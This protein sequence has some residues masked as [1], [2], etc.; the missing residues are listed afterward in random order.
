[1]QCS[2]EVTRLVENNVNL[3]HSIISKHFRGNLSEKNS[4]FDYDDL[5][6][7][8][9]I[10]LTKAA[11]AY[12]RE[13]GEFSTIAYTAIRNELLLFVKREEKHI[14]DVKDEELLEMLVS[15]DS[16]S[17]IDCALFIESLCDRTQDEDRSIVKALLMLMYDGYKLTDAANILN[18]PY[19][20]AKRIIDR[21]RKQ[22]KNPQKRKAILS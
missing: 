20:K 11:K 4:A 13:K 21:L 2:A 18:I 8:G 14:N 17:D 12:D 16:Y 15:G 7:V 22:L 9:A 19:I 6:Q 5:F 1:M 3:V 10:G